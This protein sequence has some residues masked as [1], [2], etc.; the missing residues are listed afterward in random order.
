MS[1]PS[2]TSP[3]FGKKAAIKNKQISATISSL[4][5]D[6][7]TSP[8][9]TVHSMLSD[10]T[11]TLLDH[12]TKVRAKLASLE[13][14]DKKF[15]K[16]E[17]DFVAKRVRTKDNLPLPL[18]ASKLAEATEEF[19]KL[20]CEIFKLDAY[21]AQN[22]TNKVQELCALKAKLAKENKLKYFVDT[23]VDI[24]ETLLCGFYSS[25][26]ANPALTQPKENDRHIAGWHVIRHLIDI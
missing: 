14:L 15:G 23:I 11:F 13:K 26:L 1:T 19:D 20:K 8:L 10:F 5:E 18:Q 6:K 21:H 7:I 4:L 17:T 16:D 24:F 12:H 9:R 22:F 25:G 3:K 2:V